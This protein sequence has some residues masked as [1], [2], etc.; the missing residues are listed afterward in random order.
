[1][2]ELK[3]FMHRLFYCGVLC[4]VSCGYYYIGNKWYIADY[5]KSII[6]D[7]DTYIEPFSGSFSCGFELFDIQNKTSFVLSDINPEVIN[8]WSCV[9][10]NPDRL[11]DSILC[12]VNIISDLILKQQ[13]IQNYPAYIQNCTNNFDRAALNWIGQHAKKGCSCKSLVRSDMKQFSMLLNKG[14]EYKQ[15]FYIRSSILQNV[16]INCADYI[17]YMGCKENTLIYLDPPYFNTPNSAY[18]TACTDEFSHIRLAEY[19]KKAEFDWVLSYD[20]KSEIADMY[21]F[22]KIHVIYAYNRL[23]HMNT[24]EFLIMPDRVYDKLKSNFV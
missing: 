14:Y 21:K 8:F 6:N 5:L 23:T 19:L 13:K 4:L 20:A 12:N 1:M 7:Y 22:A 24:E 10:D 15:G 17:R 18:Y 3:Q 11:Y 2:Y 16:Q 9:R